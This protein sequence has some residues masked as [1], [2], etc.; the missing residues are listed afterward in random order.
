MRFS[1]TALI[2][3][4]SGAIGAALAAQGMRGGT[5]IKPG[6]ECPP[7]PTEVRPGTCQA[8]S[9]PAPSILDYRPHST[10]VGPVL[11][12]AAVAL[13]VVAWATKTDL[14]EKLLDKVV[15]TVT[16]KVS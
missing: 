13:L 14:I 15:K 12:A 16:G 6:Q 1:R 5:Q 3:I 9:E 10:L 7:G 8:P 2:V 11:G 4:F